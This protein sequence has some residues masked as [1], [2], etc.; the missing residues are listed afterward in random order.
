MESLCLDDSFHDDVCYFFLLYKLVLVEEST[1]L[2]SDAELRK[3]IKSKSGLIV[4]YYS[5][6]LAGKYNSIPFCISCI[7]TLSLKF[8]SCNSI[9]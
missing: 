9:F 6:H 7:L 2:L 5:K 4:A 1:I 3:E 8:G